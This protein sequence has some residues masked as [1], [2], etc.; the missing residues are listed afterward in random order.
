LSRRKGRED[1]VVD[2]GQIGED[3]RDRAFGLLRAAD[4]RASDHPLGHRGE[5]DRGVTLAFAPAA[6]AGK[7][8]DRLVEMAVRQESL[9]FGLRGIVHLDEARLE[10]QHHRSLG[11]VGVNEIIVP[12]AAAR[13]G[14]EKLAHR[15]VPV[16][17]AEDAGQVPGLLQLLDRRLHQPGVAVIV[18]QDLLAETVV[19]EAD[20]HIDEVALDHLILEMDRTGH[21]DVVVGM[22]AVI[23]GRKDQ[24]AGCSLFGGVAA[25]PL[26]DLGHHKGVEGGDGVVAVLLGAA[27]GD[28]NDIVLFAVLH[29]LVADGG[30]DVG[31]RLAQFRWRRNLI[32]RQNAVDLLG[33][34]LPDPFFHAA[35]RG[36]FK[37][38]VGPVG[39][40]PSAH[41]V[42]LSLCYGS[43][44][45]F[46]CSRLVCSSLM[47]SA[48]CSR[49]IFL[50]IRGVMSM[51]AAMQL[52]TFGKMPWPEWPWA[53]T[54]LAR[55][56]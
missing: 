40:Q 11:L 32:F 2:Q 47:C 28:E 46:T 45:I 23:E 41:G 17:G 55:R 42:I 14:A 1:L 33:G 39:C 6:R 43:T 3:S 10:Q 20:H 37:E 25:D 12:F 4:G 34:G 52:I 56:T 50:V 15:T 13:L 35:D 54:T 30:L 19:P 26:E 7:G 48:V 24:I 8:I 38:E 44:V 18:D 22:A 21:A 27:D 53:P 36:I 9:H 51:P 5:F 29:H 49:V 16:E 31:S